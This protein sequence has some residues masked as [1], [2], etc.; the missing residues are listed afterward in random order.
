MFY[1]AE[2]MNMFAVSALAI[3]LF[4]GGWARARGRRSGR[5]GS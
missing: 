2:Y 1:I 5:S 4:F 3:T